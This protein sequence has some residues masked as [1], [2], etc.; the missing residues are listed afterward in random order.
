[1]GGF[2][3]G[4]IP[5]TPAVVQS[6][7]LRTLGAITG[8]VHLGHAPTPGNILL[9]MGCGF[10]NQGGVGS[11]VILPAGFGLLVAYTT[12]DQGIRA[13]IRTAQI[14]DGTDY[15]F[16]GGNGGD[17]FAVWEFTQL[18]N[19]TTIQSV[20][21]TSGFVM[22]FGVAGVTPGSYV[23]GIAESDATNALTS[24]AGATLI[25]DGSDPASS[26]PG[27]I[28]QVT[29][30]ADI[31]LTYATTTAFGPTAGLLIALS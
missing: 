31:Q 14:G 15:L 22:E 4:G 21:T 18:H 17:T 10:D 19:A 16:G 30:L 12:G 29:Q 13:G 1:M 27:V 3:G 7:F 8:T 11:Q 23:I 24:I 26:H 5:P 6:G 9:A 28:F 2:F 25:F 20:P